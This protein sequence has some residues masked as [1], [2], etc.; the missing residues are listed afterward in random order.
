MSIRFLSHASASISAGETTV[1]TDPWLAGSCFWNGWDLDPPSIQDPAALSCDAITLS[2]WHEDHF[3]KPSFRLIDKSIPVFIP[4]FPISWMYTELL[5]LGFKTVIEVDHGQ[6]VKLSS[7]LSVTFFQVQYQDDAVM[8]YESG[9]DVIINLN[10][11]KLLP[12]MAKR[13]RSRYQKTG[14]NIL[15][16]MRSYSYAW[17]FPTCFDFVAK[18]DDQIAEIDQSDYVEAFV[19]DSEW[20][21]PNVMIG[22]ASGICHLHQENVQENA[23]KVQ[24]ETVKRLAASQPTPSTVVVDGRSG[25]EVRFDDN[26]AP[27]IDESRALPRR[28]SYAAAHS[29]SPS[30]PA[31][32]SACRD[33]ARERFESFFSRCGFLFF[34]FG[35]DQRIGFYCFDSGVFIFGLDLKNKRFITDPEQG[36]G[37][38]YRVS[39]RVLG[40]ALKRH[41]FTAIDI[42]KRWR[43]TVR[44]DVSKHLYFCALFA[45]YEHGYFTLA[46]VLRWRFIRQWFMRRDDVLDYASIFLKLRVMSRSLGQVKDQLQ[47]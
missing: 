5:G 25:V 16:T 7:D 39:P 6:T 41:V 38:D 40:S 20:F 3:H 14:K 11:S 18:Q 32:V 28:L 30:T 4:R 45:V 29:D 17:S 10:D 24:F 1:V 26:G 33:I 19:H 34:M 35:L 43:V 21:S 22:F 37:F 46:N 44:D 2:H 13:I 42:S 36:F 12:R 27:R 23:H 47:R 15:A 8:V 9:D 31:H